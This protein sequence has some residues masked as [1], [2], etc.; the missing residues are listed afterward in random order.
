MPGVG[1]QRLSELLGL[2]L[3][4]LILIPVLIGALNALQLDAVTAPTSNMLDAILGA[5]PNIFAAALVVG[6]AF[7]VGRLVAG[8]VERLLAGAGFDRVLVWLGIGSDQATVAW[9]P[10]R[11]VSTLVV[12]AVMLFAAIEGSRLLGFAELAALISQFTVFGA[13]ILFGLVIFALGLFLA[14]LAARALS[15]SGVGNATLLAIVAR[16]SILVLAGAMALLQMGIA[17]EVV[18]IAF[19]LTGGAV[20]VAAAIAFGIGGRE[21]AGRLL[22]EWLQR[23]RQR[24]VI[25]RARRSS[26]HGAQPPPTVIPV[27]IGI[28]GP[29]SSP[30]LDPASRCPPAPGDRRSPSH[31]RLTTA[32]SPSLAAG[33]RGNCLSFTFSA[34]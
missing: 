3:Y 20:A 10:S 11:I 30:Y 13:Q 26:P 21:A 19:G 31:W 5:V 4:V 29:Y 28:R 1:T 7:V 17:D 22:D 2:T 32:G 14:S 15:G 12:V 24:T 27:K 16:S 34:H 23:L 9:T 6:I 8:L 25:S 33:M 18:L